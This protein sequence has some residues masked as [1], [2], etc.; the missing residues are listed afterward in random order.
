MTWPAAG[1]TVFD[2]TVTLIEHDSLAV[3]EATVGFTLAPP[4]L[5]AGA[6][7]TAP[8]Q[9]ELN[10]V[11]ANVVLG[12][13][14]LNVALVNAV[15]FGFVIVN[16]NVEVP[17]CGISPGEKLFDT[18]GAR[19]TFSVA[20]LETAPGVG[21]CVEETP[22]ALLGFAPGFEDV[23]RSVTVQE[24]PLVSVK[25][26]KVNVPVWAAVKELPLAPVHVPPAAPV[27][28]TDIFTNASLNVALVNAAPFEFCN[29]KVIRLLP[30]C[31]MV[32]VPNDLV[33][34]A[35]ATTF[36]VAVFDVD[37]AAPV[38]KVAMP[39]VVL[40]YDPT[41]AEVTLTVIVQ[42]EDAGSVPAVTLNVAPPA[43]AVVVTPVHEPPTTSGVAFTTLVG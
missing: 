15:V 42:V 22:L 31:A 28:A 3:I 33:M 23:T 34:V 14:S 5:S 24:L 8:L 4:M 37:P 30:F 27:A 17:P 32:V 16:V 2:V 40:L 1:L 25:P 26:V 6:N 35:G 41:T 10:P 29:V 38:S 19:N 36:K 13:G 18:F 21:V 20:V 43:T 39:D 11:A 9:F 12:N 7:A